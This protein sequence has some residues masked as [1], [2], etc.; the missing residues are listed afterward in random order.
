MILHNPK[1]SI[2]F[3]N[4]L[5]PL[6]KNGIDFIVEVS[7]GLKNRIAIMVYFLLYDL[8]CKSNNKEHTIVASHEHIANRLKISVRSSARAIRYLKLK[9]YIDAYQLK[10]TGKKHQPNTMKIKYPEHFLYPILEC[11]ES[12]D[13]NF[14]HLNEGESHDC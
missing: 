13:A 7:N 6:Q 14:V 11:S 3:R 12:Q 4:S 9:G 10:N 8:S 2:D 1:S 5:F